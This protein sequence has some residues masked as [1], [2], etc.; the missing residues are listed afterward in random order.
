MV[1]ITLR[2]GTRK[3]A[4][5]LG[6]RKEVLLF[7]HAYPSHHHLPNSKEPCPISRC[8]PSP[9]PR[10]PRWND[11]GCNDSTLQNQPSRAPRNQKEGGNFRKDS[12][13]NRGVA[14]LGI[15]LIFLTG[16]EL[17]GRTN[18]KT[19]PACRKQLR[20][21]SIALCFA[22][23]L[24]LEQLTPWNLRVDTCAFAVQP[25]SQLLQINVL[26]AITAKHL[27]NIL[28]HVIHTHFSTGIIQSSD[29]DLVVPM[30]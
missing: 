30:N 27:L 3:L 28:I 18:T 24:E 1:D 6:Q 14:A 15:L 2:A 4:P 21:R 16:Y 22:S 7:H 17:F 11:I 10:I 13:G 5:I 9:A 20:H 8:P 12:A 23:S 29:H 25:R 26:I 19:V